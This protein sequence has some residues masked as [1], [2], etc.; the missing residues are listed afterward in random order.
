MAVAGRSPQ[1]PREKKLV[2]APKNSLISNNLG[3]NYL[4]SLI[5]LVPVPKKS[6]NHNR[7]DNNPLFLQF[8]LVPV[9]ETSR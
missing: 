4:F 3:I 6:I 9:P 1:F 8:I 2:P 7:L 5:L